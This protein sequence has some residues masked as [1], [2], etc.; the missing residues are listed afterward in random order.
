MISAIQKL[1]LQ[2]FHAA[3]LR[4]RVKKLLHHS[5]TLNLRGRLFELLD[6]TDTPF[7]KLI[8]LFSFQ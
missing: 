3:S 8:E 7:Y 2:E 1:R 4:R 5:V 6:Y